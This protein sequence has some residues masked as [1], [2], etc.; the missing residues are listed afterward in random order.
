MLEQHCMGILFS[1]FCPNTSETTWH[2]KCW[3]KA[4][5]DTFTGKPAVS[6]MSSSLLL[7]GYYITE[8]SWVFLFN[9]GSE[10]YL[11]IAGQPWT[12]ADIDWKKS[13]FCAGLT[14]WKSSLGSC[15]YIY[16]AAITR[17]YALWRVCFTGDCQNTQASPPQ[18]RSSCRDEEPYPLRSPDQ[19]ASTRRAQ[20]SIAAK[21]VK[22]TD[23]LNHV[24]NW[25]NTD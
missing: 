7:T 17:K 2:K 11:R 25:V 24:K 1:Q 14:Y 12:G 9:V 4:H 10:V 23:L 21:A 15:Q 6:N 20:L 8:Q 22:P 18:W 16:L 13:Y 3:L 5:R 19:S